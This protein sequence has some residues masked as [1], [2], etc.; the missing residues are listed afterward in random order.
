MAT[1]TTQAAI[2]GLKIEGFGDVSVSGAGDFRYTWIWGGSLLEGMPGRD[3]YG[4]YRDGLR[5]WPREFGAAVDFLSG[6]VSTGTQAVDLLGDAFTWAL[7]ART[8]VPVAGT[9]QA[10]VTDADVSIQLSE[11]GLAAGTL[12]YLEREAIRLGAE[13]PAGT[14]ACTRAVLSTVAQAHGVDPT[15]DVE[16]FRDT[17]HPSTLAGRK[18][19]LI[20]IDIAA[21]ALPYGGETVVWNGVLRDIVLPTPDT[22]VLEL[23][24]VLGLA[25]D[26]KILRDQFRGTLHTIRRGAQTFVGPATPEPA[27]GY[28]ADRR[29]VLYVE[30]EGV[31]IVKWLPFN[32]QLFAGG[33]IERDWQ[34]VRGYAVPDIR[35]AE[36]VSQTQAWELIT[37]WQAQPASAAVPSTNTLPLSRTASSAILQLLLTTDGGGNSATYDTGKAA[38]AGGIPADLVNVEGIEAWGRRNAWAQLDN[39]VLGSEGEPLPLVDVVQDRILHQSLSVLLPG[40]GGQLTVSQMIDTPDYNDDL[41]EIDSSVI[42]SA[43]TFSIP[44]QMRRLNTAIDNAQVTIGTRPDGDPSEIIKGRDHLNRRRKGYGELS[45]VEIDAGSTTSRARGFQVAANVVAT[46][47]NPMPMITLETLRTVDVYPGELCR[48]THSLLMGLD[49]TRGLSTVRALCVGRTEQLADAGHTIRFDLLLVGA[50]Y[51]S[52]PAWIAP[53]AQVAVGGWNAGTHEVTVEANAFQTITSPIDT[54][55]GGFLAG[56]VIQV[57]DELGTVRTGHDAVSVVSV[58]GNVIELDP[59][60]LPAVPAIADGDVLRVSEYTSAASAQQEKWTFVSDV[61]GALGADNAK[62]WCNP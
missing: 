58:V 4:L 47:H 56:D 38:I 59:A 10:A 27:A 44:T 11:T 55:A 1:A 24:D 52:D 28:A 43:P 51:T 25:R 8:V 17:M 22:I 33:F 34:P 30:D 19:E 61:N 18:V 49:G 2:Y 29:M 7:L 5:R 31:A 9:L 12:I 15:D 20:T 39:L 6:T 23:D 53:S 3:P 46:F 54:D 21:P 48:L 35:A 14:Y 26:R 57:C 42:L 62:E 41:V 13:A 16:Y 45:A 40:R 60:T 32:G 50:G 36:N 37:S